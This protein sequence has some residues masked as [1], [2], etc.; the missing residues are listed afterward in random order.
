M[1]VTYQLA[2]S[3]FDEKSLKDIA[4]MTGGKYFRA[5]D[6]AKLRRIYHEIDELEK[7]KI[8]V[9]QFSKKEEQF[10]LFALLALVFAGL[11]VLL[12]NT[13]LKRLP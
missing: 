9:K 12:R 7:T 13:Y 8:N 10:Y 3:E 4:A 5:T 1:G 2:Q 11:E 6:N